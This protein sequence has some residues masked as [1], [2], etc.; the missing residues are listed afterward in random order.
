MSHRN[1]RWPVLSERAA[2]A[3]TWADHG[4]PWQSTTSPRGRAGART[5]VAISTPSTSTRTG[6]GSS[7]SCVLT[8]RR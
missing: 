3:H 7:D 2:P 4:V 5:Y 6:S 1:T 8:P